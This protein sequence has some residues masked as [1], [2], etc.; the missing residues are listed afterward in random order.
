MTKLRP[1][2]RATRNGNN[3]HDN[4]RSLSL[5]LLTAIHRFIIH[6]FPF[7]T[8]Q[9]PCQVKGSTSPSHP[10]VSLMKWLYHMT[11]FPCFGFTL[12]LDSWQRV[13]RFIMPVW[14]KTYKENEKYHLS[15]WPPFCV[16][17]RTQV[18]HPVF[19]SLSFCLSF[20]YSCY[21]FDL[22]C[23]SL[24]AQLSFVFCPVL[25]VAFYSYF[26]EHFNTKCCQTAIPIFS[27]S[28]QNIFSGW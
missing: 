9:P 13:L 6:F 8:G 17:K 22:S 28:N 21:H 19:V 10:V 26:L 3:C 27:D 12:R 14:R 11:A 16:S 1:E 5:S 7:V 2:H 24:C 23:Y 15:S 18:Y 25:F 4:F 20:L